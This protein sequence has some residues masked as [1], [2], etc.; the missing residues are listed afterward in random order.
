MKC[1]YIAGPFSAPTAWKIEQN[2]R[3]AE[4]A[5]YLV[6][7]LGAVPLIPHA[8]TR[9]F[10][11]DQSPEFWYAATLELLKRADAVLLVEGWERSPGARLEREKALAKGMP[12]FE[13]AADL[14]RWLEELANVPMA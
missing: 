12:V 13:K 2:V 8:N 10:H 3:R 4:E 1:I 14:G 9:F 6:A 5:G 11:G 7:Q